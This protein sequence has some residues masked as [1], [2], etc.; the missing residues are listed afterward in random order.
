MGL[1]F[2][3]LRFIGSFAAGILV[4]GLMIAA[5]VWI[6]GGKSCF[7][8]FRKREVCVANGQ[9]ALTV[10]RPEVSLRHD[11]Y[12]GT[13]TV[14]VRAIQEDG[15]LGVVF[16]ED[17]TDEPEIRMNMIAECF[18]RG[19]RFRGYYLVKVWPKGTEPWFSETKEN[20]DRALGET[21]NPWR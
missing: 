6:D 19:S 11:L 3:A 5:L 14:A 12:A 16:K 15:S 20:G 9:I 10:R 4:C 21:P 2:W 13:W 18:G 1:A 8:D 7:S 17:Y